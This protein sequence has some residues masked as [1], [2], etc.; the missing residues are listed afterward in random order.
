MSYTPGA[1]YGNEISSA[2][3]ALARMNEQDPVDE[4]PAEDG[5]SDFAIKDRDTYLQALNRNASARELAVREADAA[6]KEQL[7][8]ARAFIE[9]QRR[10]MTGG[11]PFFRLAAALTAPQKTP[12]FGGFLQNFAPAIADM[13]RMRQEAEQARAK[14]LLELEQGSTAEG[15]AARME[16]IK[17]RD[18]ELRG[19]MGLFKAPAAEYTATPMG[20]V[21]NKRTGFEKPGASHVNALLANPNMAR[22]FDIKFGPGAAQEVFKLYGGR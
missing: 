20:V 4:L 16:A 22:D 1:L 21:F 7:A 14:Q 11:E 15:L 17:A 18:V 3:E 12:G 2:R 8:K 19:A 13:T 5:G 6:R 10:P 9:Q